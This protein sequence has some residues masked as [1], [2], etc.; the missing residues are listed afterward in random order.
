[1]DHHSI[2]EEAKA[3][4]Y[5][6]HDSDSTGHDYWH[7][8]RVYNNAR[9]LQA[10]EGGDRFIIEVAAL[11]H[12]MIDYKLTD[13]EHAQIDAIKAFLEA[14]GVGADVI[15]RII[16]AMQ[17]VSYK[18]GNNTVEVAT[19]EDAIVQDADRLDALGAVG[20]ARTFIYGGNKRHAL[21]D[22][23]RAAREE[24]TF[25]QYS[26]EDNTM[27]NHFYEKLLKLKGL[28][29][30]DAAKRVAE[31]RHQ[32]MEMYLEQFYEEWEGRR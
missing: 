27:I 11:F 25:E 20:I 8:M 5:E 12:D 24:L 6:F 16:H 15:E 22:P 28:M 18:G 4:V 19:V 23:D 30:T 26:R 31:A 13:D 3:R 29:H 1:M 7:V 9:M 21:Y 2:I 32:F 14:R 10:E 17:A